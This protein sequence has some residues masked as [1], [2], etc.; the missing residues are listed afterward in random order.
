[1]WGISPLTSFILALI[2]AVIAKLLILGISP[3]TSFVLT[4]RKALVAKLVT[5]GVLYSIFFILALYTTFLT[6]S[7]FTP[8]LSLLKSTRNR[9]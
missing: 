9:C 6:T 7:F 8:S 3:L 1:M 5:S 4:L 2:A